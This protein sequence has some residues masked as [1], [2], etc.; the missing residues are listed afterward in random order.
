MFE[1]FTGYEIDGSDTSYSLI[2]PNFE[3]LK[4][5]LRFFFSLKIINKNK[6]IIINSATKKVNGKNKKIDELSNKKYTKDGID[7]LFNDLL[8]YS[9]ESFRIKYTYVNVENLYPEI[10]RELI[11][12]LLSSDEAVKSNNYTNPI[13][14]RINY[15]YDNVIGV[16]A[17]DFID[18]TSQG[19]LDYYDDLT[20]EKLLKL[21]M[22]GDYYNISFDLSV[23]HGYVSPL[24]PYYAMEKISKKFPEYELNPFQDYDEINCC[25]KLNTK[26]EINECI[27]ISPLK[28]IEF[29]RKDIVYCVE[30]IDNQEPIYI[31]K[32]KENKNSKKVSVEE[33]ATKV[34]TSH[35]L[36]KRSVFKKY[37]PYSN[38]AKE[39]TLNFKGLEY[40]LGKNIY[41]K[42]YK[43]CS[44]LYKYI[45]GNSDYITIENYIKLSKEMANLNYF[46]DIEIKKY[47]TIYL[48]IFESVNSERCFNAKIRYNCKG[49]NDFF[50]L[51]I[52][53]ECKKV[54]NRFIN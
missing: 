36:S 21:Y 41:P 13:F 8:K 10:K 9:V 46:K 18:V 16:S 11:D 33:N 7:N 1:Y 12:F 4:E 24:L 5:M 45:D 44:L 48:Q 42:E 35:I 49:E 30:V 38:K 43:L 39:E 6:P 14:T 53:Y 20:P 29:L 32:D 17:T 22:V 47:T 51:I 37:I 54:I 40:D 34:Y 31:T 3:K 2:T 15:Y 19:D 28:L 25:G 52:P 27:E 23:V 50:E 26:F